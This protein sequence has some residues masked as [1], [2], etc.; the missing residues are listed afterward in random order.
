MSPPPTVTAATNATSPALAPDRGEVEREVGQGPGAA[1]EGAHTKRNRK[2]REKA[3]RRRSQVSTC[4]RPFRAVH[5]LTSFAPPHPPRPFQSR[6]SGDAATVDQNPDASTVVRGQRPRP[7]RPKPPTSG[8]GDSSSFSARAPTSWSL[9]QH[10]PTTTAPTLECSSWSL[11]HLAPAF[12]HHRHGLTLGGGIDH[13]P[14]YVGEG[15]GGVGG[16]GAPRTT[17]DGCQ[18]L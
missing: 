2:K 16:G 10:R 13:T 11:D 6:A 7:E 14:E 15:L 8:H 4:A 3:K 17:A 9:D 1:G 12:L 5:A 18:R